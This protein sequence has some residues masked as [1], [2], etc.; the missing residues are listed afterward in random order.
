MSP[1]VLILILIDVQYPQKAIFNFEKGLIG[2][3]HSSSGSQHP[4]KISPSK[5]SD[6]PHY[7]L[8]FRKPCYMTSILERVH[9]QV[10]VILLLCPV[11]QKFTT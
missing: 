7:L 6:S 11:Y 4:V 10:A 2:Q 8:L 1:F 5:I 3:N 9:V